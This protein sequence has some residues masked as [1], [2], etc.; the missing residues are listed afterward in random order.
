ML[1]NGAGTNDGAGS[2]I[3]L[4]ANDGSLTLG[5]SGN[6]FTLNADGGPG[7]G[8]GGTI[9]SNGSTLALSITSGT[10]VTASA[11]SGNADGGAIDLLGQTVSISSATL[12]ADANGTGTAGTL[13]I[14]SLSGDSGMSVTGSTISAKGNGDGS[15]NN[16]EL[17]A[18]ADLTID[19]SSMI[20]ASS[21]GAQGGQILISFGEYN[22]DKTLTW[23]GTVNAKA[24]S[25]VGGTVTG[26]SAT[27]G[28]I[29]TN[30]SFDASASSGSGGSVNLVTSYFDSANSISMPTGSIDVSGS[31]SS[32]LGSINFQAGSVEGATVSVSVDSLLGK[33]QATGRDVTVST[34]QTA[35]AGDLTISKVAAYSGNISLAASQAK[36]KILPAGITDPVIEAWGNVELLGNG[37]DL[38]VGASTGNDSVF[39]YG[40]D[41]PGNIT[42]KTTNASNADINIGT[43]V[44]ADG[45]VTIT[46]HGSGNV[47]ASGIGKISGFTD[48]SSNSLS[49][50]TNQGQIGSS[51]A[52]LAVA[53]SSLT[54]GTNVDDNKPVY[55]KNDTGTDNDL[56]ITSIQAGGAVSVET[57]GD[58][59][60]EEIISAGSTA[61]LKGK[62]ITVNSN[63]IQA[64]DITLETLSDSDGDIT[65]SGNLKSRG[66]SA[67]VITTHN[68]GNILSDG[69][70]VGGNGFGSP[71]LDLT[72][73]DGTIGADD[74]PLLTSAGSA[75]VRTTGGSINIKNSDTLSLFL[76]EISAAGSIK[77]ESEHGLQAGSDIASTS[78]GDIEIIADTNQLTLGTGLGNSITANDGNIYLY[79]KDTSN[80]GKVF[81]KQYETVLALNGDV[82]IFRGPKPPFED[83]QYVSNPDN[84][85]SGVLAVTSNGGEIWWGSPASGMNQPFLTAGG[86]DAV[87]ADGAKIVFQSYFNG[88]NLILEGNTTIVATR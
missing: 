84:S 45:T 17:H 72:T 80:A 78:E 19:S 32:T 33:V 12:S 26:V 56:S 44:V 73:E 74:D 10:A 46:G 38:G 21:T 39:A 77:I 29:V 3:N 2:T 79:T 30:A 34:A 65:F 13:K 61:T 59:I 48:E 4:F 23:N 28:N 69:G 41:S 82:F 16:V 75:R 76:N 57:V 60:S 62:A 22:F 58:I 1:L 53:V 9:T 5:A 63:G 14:Q 71:I 35:A 86:P 49:V 25:G 50:T 66:S 11:K 83:N 54:A 88:A 6:S 7:G 40:S 43:T 37:I 42:L 20:D 24:A 87:H 51:S 47:T 36:L 55:I 70:I 27:N 8:K 52:P 18:G 85:P 81:L 15:T 68:A 67:I 31:S 64:N